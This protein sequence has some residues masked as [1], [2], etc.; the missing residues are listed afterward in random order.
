VLEYE[1][2]GLNL[3]WETCDGIH[4]HSGPHQPQ[5]LEG[6]VVRIADRIAY[7]NHDI[8]DALRAGILSES[9]L[10][11]APCD[12]L[13]HTSNARITTL[14]NDVIASSVGRDHISL[15]PKIEEAMLELRRFMF[16]QVYESDTAKG[17][18]PKAKDLVKTLF[19][20]YLDHS[21][22]VPAEYRNIAGTTPV[23]AAVDFV[24]GMTDRYALR[25]YEQLFLP[26]S[27]QL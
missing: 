19:A 7:I 25:R 24:A 3:C 21:D 5:T 26:H 27:W 16:A 11:A 2:K 15:S 14:V 4:G 12:V 13:G 22:R 17:E 18:E 10:P 20:W 23:Q 6:Q 9:D 8:D 1:G